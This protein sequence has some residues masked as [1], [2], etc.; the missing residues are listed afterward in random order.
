MGWEK[1]R[2]NKYYYRKCRIGGR[3]VSEYLGASPVA[4]A[5]AALDELKRQAREEER[6]LFRRERE[7]QR[8]IDQEVDRVCRLIRNLTHATLLL[9]RYHMYKGQWRKKR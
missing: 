6:Q 2:G 5:A 8:E 4:K 7:R 9:N 1:R 3:V